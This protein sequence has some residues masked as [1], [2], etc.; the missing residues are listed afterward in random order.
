MREGRLAIIDAAHER[1]EGALEAVVREQTHENLRVY[2]T[3]PTRVDEDAGQEMNLAHGGYGKRQ[4]LELVQNGADAMTSSPG[5]GIKV[6]LTADHLYCANDGEPVSAGGIRSLLHAHLSDK[7]G[8]EIGRFGLGFKSVL[9]VTDKPEF[10]SRPVSF[11]FDAAWSR[12]QIWRVAPERERYPTLRLA[13]ILDLEDAR[14]AD[15]LLDELMA[16]ATTVVRLP[17]GVGGSSW[18]SDDIE[19][20]DPAFM[21]FSPHVGELVLSDRTT[22]TRRE[23]QLNQAGDEVTIREGVDNRRWRVFTSRVR[24]SQRAKSE[25]W[26]LSARDELPVVWAVPLGGR[27]TVGRFWA[28]F[29]LRDETTITGIVNA[30][31]QINDD[32]VGLL[33][34]SQLNKELLD[35]L[36]RLVVSSVPKLTRKHDPGWVLD[37]LP[38]RAKD[39][40]CW[41][42]G[43]LISRFYDIAPDYPLV[44]DQDGRL[45]LV[46]GLRLPPAKLHGPRWKPGPAR[47]TGLRNGAMR[48]PWPPRR[49]DTVS[50]ASSRRQGR[51]RRSHRGGL[52]PS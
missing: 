51:G 32:R 24:P 39:A 36:C 13:R 37:I 34:G 19:S 22:G 28:F 9:G 5:G 2:A 3:S 17:R 12:A 11:G 27:I 42:D 8:T 41:G 6:V 10:Y 14:A 30:P 20:F 47:R 18:L 29:P 1:E 21:L 7:R 49:G 38:A 31:W 48:A 15:P 33:E 16:H 45:R 26:E 46:S 23:I 52:S 44:P 35:A 50:N 43:Y 25:A 4:L 40:R